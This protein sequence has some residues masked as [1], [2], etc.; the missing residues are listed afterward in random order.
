MAQRSKY[1]R[2]F[3]S[4]GVCKLNN[5]A[6]MG[7]QL[8]KPVDYIS[9][10]G[11]VKRKCK[12]KPSTYEIHAR[13]QYLGVNMVKYRVNNVLFNDVF[14]V[15]VQADYVG[16]LC[17]DNIETVRAK[18]DMLNRIGEVEAK[19]YELD[20][21][22]VVKLVPVIFLQVNQFTQ[23]KYGC[24]VKNEIYHKKVR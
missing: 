7:Y 14:H 17:R 12:D 24:T 2:G 1:V 20:G 23:D 13:Q 8:Y 3:D 21:H 10:L 19:C 16:I 4:P 15:D 11:R 18:C 22:A 5:Q 9:Q 6:I